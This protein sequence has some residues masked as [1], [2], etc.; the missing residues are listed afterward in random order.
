MHKK[1]L[2]LFGISGDVILKKHG[3]FLHDC[4]DRFVYLYAVHILNLSLLLKN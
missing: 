3:Q 4:I 1:E 2:I